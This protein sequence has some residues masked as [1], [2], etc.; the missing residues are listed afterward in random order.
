MWTRKAVT[1]TGLG[2]ILV[3]FA[4]FINNLQL[5][6]LGITLLGFV[7]VHSLVNTSPVSVNITRR[8]SDSQIFEGQEVE[9]ELVIQNRGRSIGFL[10]IYDQLPHEVELAG[11]LNHTIVR[12]HRNEALLAHYRLECHLR[13]QYQLGKPRLRLYNPSFLFYYESDVD[14][15]STL[16]VFP[17]IEALEGL[18]LSS[19]FP[20]MYQGAMP[21][22]R[23]GTSGEF[24]SI[25]EYHPGDDFKNINWRVFGRTRKL[26]VNQ[27]EREDISD[28]ML[29]LDAR[30]I[31][32][33]GTPVHNPLN[34]GCR[35]AAA[36]VDYFLHTRNRVGL[37]I[38]GEAVESIGVDSGER[39][40]YRLLTKLSEVRPAGALGLH[41]VVGELRNFTPRSPV[42]VISTLEQDP[43]V[44]AALREITAHGFKLTLIAPDTLE[45]DRESR[46]ISPAV[47]FTAS[48]ELDNNISEARS[49][50]AR[51]LRWDPD[52]VLGP[53][54]Q[55][56]VK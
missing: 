38:Y 8:F 17:K 27:F 53:A 31:A 21:I 1:Y 40:L 37:T 47:Y 26:M 50:G 6:L 45:F 22:R 2:T 46:I 15:E 33:T 32:G 41:T 52:S 35:A 19:D 55:E 14:S 51:A 20:K 54:L 9:V 3:L 5:L 18:D 4:P 25:R 7:A 29:V 44:H 34:Y 42:I 13:G 28:V 10:E 36:L 23:I 48:A 30:E 49:L 56:V 11:G 39:H 12:L 24:Y 43:T 16:V